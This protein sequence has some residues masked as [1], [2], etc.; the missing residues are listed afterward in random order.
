MRS[1]FRFLAISAL[2][3]LVAAGGQAKEP[4]GN[5]ALLPGFRL[6][7]VY[8]VPTARQG[9][10]VAMTVDPQG[11]ILASNQFG[12]IYEVTPS[13]IGSKP[14]RTRVKKL[15][16]P[17]SMAQGLACTDD[18]LYIVVNGGKPPHES[19]LYRATDTS[20]NGR[21]DDVE[22]LRVFR[23]AG[24]HGPHAVIV[25]PEGKSL[26]FCCGNA[27]EPPLFRRSL[28]PPVWADDQLLPQ[29]IDPQGQAVKL[30]P[31][32]GWI[33]RTDLEGNTLEFFSI[34][35]RNHYDMAFNGDGEL[36]AFDGDMEWDVATPWYRP[37]RICHVPSG[38]DFGW[39]SGNAKW[40]PWYIDSLPP[41]VEIGPGS[42]TGLAF[43][44]GAKFP[45]KYQRALFGADW[46]NG[47]I[48]AIHLRPDG[49]TYAGDYEYFAT[50]MP[51]PVTDLAVNPKDG[52][53]YFTVGGRKSASSLYRIVYTGEGQEEETSD[54]A[55][56][57]AASERGATARRQRRQLEQLHVAAEP[58]AI[59]TIWPHLASTDRAVRSA[60]RIA[61]EHQPLER[62]LERGAAEPSPRIR[63]AALAAAARVAPKTGDVDQQED[64]SDDVAEQ[65]AQQQQLHFSSLL[66]L[67]LA[68]LPAVDQRDL[69][70]ALALSIIRLGPVSSE[71][72]ER[73]TAHLLPHFPTK[74]FSVDRQLASTLA[75]L[76]SPSITEP[77]V[78]WLSQVGSSTEEV[79]FAVSLSVLRRGWTID[80]RR[81]LLKWFDAASQRGGGGSSFAYLKA[82][83]ARFVAGCSQQERAALADL[84]KKPLAEEPVQLESSARPFVKAWSLDELTRLARDST[85]TPNYERGEAMFTAAS[86]RQC[87]RL[88]SLGS[89]IG[90]DLTT[91]GRRYG[92]GDLLRAI[93]EPNHEIPDQYQQTVFQAGGRTLVGRITNHAKDTVSIS[94]NIL[95]PKS[96]V[97][98]SRKAI[99]LQRP[100]DVSMMPAGLLNTLSGEEILDLLAFLRA[101]GDA[102]HVL[103]Q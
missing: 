83:R 57:L 70:R 22:Q 3:A 72:R 51:M 101:G 35:F 94:T 7:L 74:D 68:N 67:D 65:L 27:T 82:A 54:L 80:L 63:I 28:A 43:G 41:V 39:R 50:A 81:R 34:G 92:V 96:D 24:E 2:A 13:K 46:G 95:D 99:S 19:G 29:L 73:L 60:A 17:I 53:L 23:G 8:S 45:G 62:W 89:T 47:A 52:A 16:L 26:Y 100:S 10:W 71:D 102:K 36:F 97:Q 93:V 64:Q 88:G 31:P 55:A 32:G 79:E 21:W 86:C 44:Y 37:T 59:D 84:I 85:H 56:D 98:V 48:Y 9:S 6:E 76:G 66:E 87:H 38:V 20:G 33:A 61:L 14:F 91:V 18:A 42:P 30:Q 103:Y 12:A 4:I 78:N 69:M 1:L 11:R 49:A 25:G 40:P 15:R 75:F 77:L 58:T 90:P 5:V